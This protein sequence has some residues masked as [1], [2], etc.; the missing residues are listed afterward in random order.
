[1]S[2]RLLKVG[3]LLLRESEIASVQVKSDG[4]VFIHL[5]GGRFLQLEAGAGQ[6]L[7]E[8]LGSE[9]VDVSQGKKG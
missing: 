5:V 3:D 6:Q 4:K 2:E 9:A 7:L 1:M 8:Y